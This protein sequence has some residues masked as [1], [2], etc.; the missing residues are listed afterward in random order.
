MKWAGTISLRLFLLGEF[1]AVFLCSWLCGR[2]LAV[3][4]LVDEGGRVDEG[5][6]ADEGSKVFKGR[7]QDVV[8][9][10]WVVGGWMKDEGRNEEDGG[11]ERG[12]YS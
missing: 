1:D 12:F 5:S 6:K 4:M 11:I 10:V 8:V 2:V 9:W 3:D 7:R